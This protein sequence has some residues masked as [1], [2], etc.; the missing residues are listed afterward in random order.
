[1]DEHGEFCLRGGIVD[2]FPTNEAQPVRLEFV[3][4]IIESI[5][6]FDPAT[7]RSLAAVDRIRIRPQRELLLLETG[8]D[9][10]AEDRSAT[11][12]DYVR[13]ARADVIVFEP[14]DVRART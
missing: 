3:G 4:D 7:Q 9:L 12:I 10:A 13:R 2:L 1:V 5:R 6:R 14:D 11:F 8:G